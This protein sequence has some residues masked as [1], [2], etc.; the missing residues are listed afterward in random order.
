MITMIITNQ[1]QLKVP[2]M[3]T[4]NIM[5]VEGKKTKK[6]LVEQ[7]L[8]MIIPYLKQLINNHRAINNNSNEWKIQIN[9]HIKFFFF[10]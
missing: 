3:R 8:N 4:I 7:Y 9:M 5:K 1:Y 10:K 2:L 6:I